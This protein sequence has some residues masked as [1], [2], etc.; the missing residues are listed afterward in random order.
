M[1]SGEIPQHERNHR[2]QGH[3]PGRTEVLLVISHKAPVC[4]QPREC[5]L[6]DPSAGDRYKTF[7]AV[8][9]LDA[10]KRYAHLIK[11]HILECTTV[12]HIRL[13]ER[14]LLVIRKYAAH[15][16]LRA[17]RVMHV[18]GRDVGTKR[19]SVAVDSDMSLDALDTL[20]PVN[21]G[22]GMRK[23]GADALTVDDRHCREQGMPRFVSLH[24]H[25]GTEGLLKISPGAPA[26][27][28]V[29]DCLVG[30]IAHRETAPLAAGI[31]YEEDGLKD[32]ERVMLAQLC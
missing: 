16:P 12:A 15:H 4:L 24:D 27:V 28:V 13:D 31:D 5:A 11:R 25:K 23:A 29:I 21:A 1:E 20:A 7:L 32:I 14:N 18:C 6:H 17:L 22:D 2:Q 19:I 10:F 26:A 3:V 8:I 9:R 30:R